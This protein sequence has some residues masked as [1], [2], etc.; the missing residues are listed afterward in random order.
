MGAHAHSVWSRAVADAGGSLLHVCGTAAAAA[1]HCA[2]VRRTIGAS[3]SEYMSMTA[4]F[5]VTAQR[6][7]YVLRNR[8]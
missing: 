8:C 5:N 7:F 6:S 4:V 3:V 1:V 2:D